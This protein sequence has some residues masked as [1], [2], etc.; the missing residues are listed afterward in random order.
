MVGRDAGSPSSAGSVHPFAAKVR[1]FGMSV[2]TRSR[3]CALG[4]LRKTTHESAPARPVGHRS[5]VCLPTQAPSRLAVVSEGTAE[6]GDRDGLLAA[7]G[8]E[9]C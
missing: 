5:G 2:G 1:R 7:L 8:F 9:A 3:K 6:N 4:P